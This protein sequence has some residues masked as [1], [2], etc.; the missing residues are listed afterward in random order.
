M[1]KKIVNQIKRVLKHCHE[2]NQ[3][4]MRLEERGVGSS[5]THDDYNINKG[6]VEALEFVINAVENGSPVAD[7]PLIDEDVSAEIQM[8]RE[9]KEAEEMTQLIGDFIKTK[10]N[11]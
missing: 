8:L 5:L 3:Q 11:K 7:T 4:H 6:W 2:T 10:E 1:D 9:R